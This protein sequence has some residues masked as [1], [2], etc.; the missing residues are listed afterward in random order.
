MLKLHSNHILPHIQ[1]GQDFSL[2]SDGVDVVISKSSTH[3]IAYAKDASENTFSDVV[4][5]DETAFDL[6][7]MAVNSFLE[8]A[9][10]K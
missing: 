2:S 5:F 8:T 10:Y 7:I 4:L 3:V 1:R 9:I 6:L